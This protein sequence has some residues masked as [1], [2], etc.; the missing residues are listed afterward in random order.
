[1]GAHAGHS[2]HMGNA[3]SRRPT[4]VGWATAGHVS[5]HTQFASSLWQPGRRQCVSQA[6]SGRCSGSTYSGKDRAWTRASGRVRFTRGTRAGDAGEEGGERA[7]APLLPVAVRGA[8]SAAR[9]AER[10]G[11]GAGLGGSGMAQPPRDSPASD[12]EVPAG[13]AAGGG[14]SSST[15]VGDASARPS[16]APPT[17][18][19]RGRRAPGWVGSVV[20]AI[21]DAAPGGTGGG[22][23]AGAGGRRPACWRSPDLGTG[24]G[25]TG[26]PRRAARPARSGVLRLGSRGRFSPLAAAAIARTLVVRRVHA[27]AVS[28]P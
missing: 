18:S 26:S 27:G 17:V 10:R 4:H 6:S 3:P 22:G 13:Y 7:P 8:P 23:A 2:Q 28:K 21:G 11:G 5:Q 1:M 16:S 12:A 9:R 20:P 15:A 14:G 19:P 25:F 24:R